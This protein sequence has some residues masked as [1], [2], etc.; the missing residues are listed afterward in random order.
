MAATHGCNA[1]PVQMACSAFSDLGLA[2]ILVLLL[3]DGSFKGFEATPPFEYHDG[4]FTVHYAVNNYL[5]KGDLTPLQ[6]E[7]MW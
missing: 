1:W 5:E 6:E 2:Q 4:W 3:Q 7:A